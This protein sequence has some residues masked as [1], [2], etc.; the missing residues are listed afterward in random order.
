MGYAL[1]W[2][3]ILLVFV[4]F[5]A[6]TIYSIYVDELNQHPGEK[7]S[8]GWKEEQRIP[9]KVD[10]HATISEVLEEV[11]KYALK[12]ENTD[13]LLCVSVRVREEDSKI[14]RYI[15]DYELSPI[16]EFEGTLRVFVV[17]TDEGWRIVLGNIDYDYPIIEQASREY[18]LIEDLEQILGQGIQYLKDNQVSLEGD[19]YE[20]GINPQ[21][22]FFFIEGGSDHTVH[23]GWLDINRE[24][25]TPVL[26]RRKE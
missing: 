2:K 22:V 21:A 7:Y 18:V 11:N 8:R 19:E 17:P 14:L 5:V 15:F 10:E 20:L 26:E 6:F 25:E 1:N 16:G 23:R 4:A 3:V 12:W 24:G 13:S 9:L